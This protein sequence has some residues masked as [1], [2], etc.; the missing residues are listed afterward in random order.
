MRLSNLSGKEVINLSDGAR[1]GI[2]EECE[3]TFDSN[4]GIIQTI[5]LPKKNGL[6]SFFSD[7]KS[8][9]IPWRAI[10]RIGDEVIIVDINN[11]YD[12]YTNLNRDR[13]ENTY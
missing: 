7:I 12:R 13:H 6:F 8:S 5:L 3:L 9:T 10:K 4:S 11:A 2:I 1:L